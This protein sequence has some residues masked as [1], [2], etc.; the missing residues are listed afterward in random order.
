MIAAMTANRI[1]IMQGRLVPPEGDRFQAFPRERWADEL[2][3]AESVPIAFIEWIHDA[4]GETV[5]PLF[6]EPALLVELAARYHLDQR[7]ICADWFMDY[8]LLRCSAPELDERIGALQHL[9]SAAKS[10]HVHRIV[11]PFVDASRLSVRKDEDILV[12]IIER[13]LPTIEL[14]GVEVHLETDLAPETFC[15]LL[16][17]IPHPMIKVNYDSGNSASSGFSVAEEFSAYGNRIGS[18]HIKDRLLN[19]GT[20]AL[21]RGGADFEALFRNLK[22]IHYLGDF[23]LQTARGQ[24]GNEVALARQNLAF[25]RQY[26]DG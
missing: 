1:G 4:Y 16:E 2:A 24:V 26:W 7:S 13:L 14:L 3:L 6:N 20:V 25:I 21:G 18:V 10:I 15:S 9:L 12:G 5:N 17:R 8:P 19:G 11:L 23:T 22:A